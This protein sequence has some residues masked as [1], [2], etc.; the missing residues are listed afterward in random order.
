MTV[1][2]ILA[3]NMKEFEDLTNEASKKLLS[4]SGNK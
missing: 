2:E 4:K 1:K 3:K